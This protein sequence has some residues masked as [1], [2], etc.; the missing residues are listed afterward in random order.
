[1]SGV[2]CVFMS[3]LSL[4]LPAPGSALAPSAG[5]MLQLSFGKL[6]CILELWRYADMALEIRTAKDTV[7]DVSRENPVFLYFL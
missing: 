1:M 7:V 6:K 2:G 4:K 3:P 5:C